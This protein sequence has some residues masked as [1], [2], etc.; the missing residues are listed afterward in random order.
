MDM[1]NGAKDV[2]NMDLDKNKKA[3]SILRI[4]TYS[5]CKKTALDIKRVGRPMSQ[6]RCGDS[7]WDERGVRP[8]WS[9]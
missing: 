2:T 7:S 3:Y 8:V 6:E 9:I 4:Y 5:R 1:E